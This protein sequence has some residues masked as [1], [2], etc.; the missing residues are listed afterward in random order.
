MRIVLSME[1]KYNLREITSKA[2]MCTSVTCPAIYDSGRED[3]ETYIVVGN[4]RSAEELGI[5]H[6][7]DE[8]AVEIPKGLLKS[9]L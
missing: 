6:G 7:K 5:T 9:I 4:R 8:A 2:D 3:A 1:N